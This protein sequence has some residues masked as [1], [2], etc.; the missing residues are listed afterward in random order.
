MMCV[1]SQKPKRN[2]GTKHCSA[3]SFG[4]SR[5]LSYWNNLEFGILKWSASSLL[6][7]RGCGSQLNT[8]QPQGFWS[9][10]LSEFFVHG[11]SWMTGYSWITGFGSFIPIFKGRCLNS[12]IRHVTPPKSRSQKRNFI[13]NELC[14]AEETRGCHAFCSFFRVPVFNKCSVLPAYGY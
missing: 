4:Y 14:V 6:Q 12:G 7:L 1:A 3:W 2:T 13:K 5:R 9:S 11:Y 8:F 10:K